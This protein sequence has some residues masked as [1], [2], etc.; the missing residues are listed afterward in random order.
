MGLAELRQMIPRMLDAAT[1]DRLNV[2]VRPL[3]SKAWFIQL[4]DLKAEQLAQLAPRR[5]RQL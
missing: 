5:P 1:A 3:S 2:I 4:D